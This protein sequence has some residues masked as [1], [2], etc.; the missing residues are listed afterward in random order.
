MTSDQRRIFRG[1]MREL[2]SELNNRC[3]LAMRVL[4]QQKTAR[5]F[6]DFMI[7]KIGGKERLKDMPNITKR[8]NEYRN[9][10]KHR[11]KFAWEVFNMDIKWIREFTNRTQ[12]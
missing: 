5:D 8:M 6:V 12:A 11:P 10:P 9:I 1:I 2:W 4:L 7:E 3:G